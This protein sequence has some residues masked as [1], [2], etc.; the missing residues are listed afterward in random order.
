MKR[1][2][3]ALLGLNLLVLCEGCVVAA[4]GVAGAGAGT[5]AYLKGELQSTYSFP[6]GQCWSQTLL[7]IQ[8]LKL[9]VDR[10]QMDALGGEIEARRA[11]G[12]PVKVQ[13]KP[14]SEHSTL[15]G[16]RVGTLESVWSKKNAKRIHHA[17][18]KRLGV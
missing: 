8:D 15:I 13:L 5:Y 3:Y 16:V 7:A 18:Q 9:T 4:V 14:A 2:I 12:T 17:I 10:K 11:D 6:L 1:L